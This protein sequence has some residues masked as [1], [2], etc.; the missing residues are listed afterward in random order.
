VPINK[1]H[2]TLLNFSYVRP[3]YNIYKPPSL[4]PF[5]DSLIKIGILKCG[6]I[7][8]S[9]IVELLF[10][11]RGNRENIQI[12]M[13]GTG[14]KMGECEAEYLAKNASSLD[15][16]DLIMY[17][18]PNLNSPGPRRA[19]ELLSR[20]GTPAILISDGPKNPEVPEQLGYIIIPCDPMMGV[21][22]EFLDPTEMMIFNADALKVLA[23]TGAARMAQD[24]V[25]GI[26]KAIEEGT[27]YVLPRLILTRDS[28]IE[29]ARYKNPYAKAKAMAA[30]DMA[31]RVSEMN[32]EGCFQ[33]NEM[34]QYIPIVAAAHEM[35]RHAA[36]LCDEAR[37][38]EKS[39]DSVVRFPHRKMGMTL[40]K[41]KLLEK[42]PK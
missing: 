39:N 25:D 37:E 7:A 21:R 28:A 38:I 6:N 11:E 23:G 10:D 41:R 29:Y 12:R 19:I 4:I 20:A 31:M 3:T 32:A 1:R 35:L 40:E 14:A 5:C 30:F 16:S 13:L 26:I 15:E 36:M 8:L 42:P 22:R 18:S 9:T 33:K 2:E 17:L 34:G 27:Q 24:I